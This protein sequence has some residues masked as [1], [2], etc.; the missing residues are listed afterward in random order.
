MSIPL[1]EFGKT[2]IQNISVECVHTRPQCYVVSEASGGST[3]VFPLYC[4]LPQDP[5][6]YY[7]EPSLWSLSLAK[8]CVDLLFAAAALL[9]FWPVLLITAVLVRYESPGP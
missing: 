7:A 3:T 1:R 5:T 9:I 2:R 6:V 4:P 8:R